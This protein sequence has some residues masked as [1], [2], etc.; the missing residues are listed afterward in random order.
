[1]YLGVMCNAIGAGVDECEGSDMGVRWVVE[2]IAEGV[3]V[4]N[5]RVA[6]GITR[7]GARGSF[8]DSA[9]DGVRV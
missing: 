3:G 1:M 5:R 4:N 7:G 8:I 9:K 6:R 2:R